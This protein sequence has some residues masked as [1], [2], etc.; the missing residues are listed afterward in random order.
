MI[1]VSLTNCPPRLR[2]DLTKWLMEINAGVYVGN[3]SARVRDE[4]WDRICENVRDGRAT[5][6][7]S[8]MNEQGM[9]FRVHNTTWIPIDYDG[10]QLM[11][12]PEG[13]TLQK[14]PAAPLS[15]AA[16]MQKVQRIR[17]AQQRKAKEQ[18]YV[19]VDVETTGL[20]ADQHEIMEIAAI[21]IVD[22]QIADSFS[23]LIR[24]QQPV[25]E[26]IT[27]LTGIDDELLRR[28]GRPLQ[29]AMQA[30][31]AFV[32][33]RRVLCHNAGFDYAFLKAACRKCRLPEFKNPYADTLRM[34]ERQLDDVADHKLTTLA[35]YFGLDVSGAH[36]ALTDCRLTFAVY[37]KLNEIR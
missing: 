12:R 35:A 6:V 9:D 29:E 2:G 20:R 34:A 23:V 28:E 17:A 4:L 11:L 25:P 16:Q 31:L 18:G 7:F 3:V 26:T 5:M 15:R 36:R 8:A 13:K 22:H 30:F 10:L 24:I 19:V 21:H 14:D 33:T 1:V 37:E 27:Q 32:D